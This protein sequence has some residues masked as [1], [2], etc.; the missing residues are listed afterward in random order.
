MLNVSL[1]SENSDSIA[2]LSAIC[3]LQAQQI[4]IAL[5]LIAGEGAAARSKMG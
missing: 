5:A 2:Y 1:C 4:A 3:G